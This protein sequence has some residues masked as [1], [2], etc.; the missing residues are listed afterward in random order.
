MRVPPDGSKPKR[1]WR[2]GSDCCDGVNGMSR[3]RPTE[4]GGPL[5]CLSDTGQS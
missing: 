5:Q 1:F 3:L 4:Q 2:A